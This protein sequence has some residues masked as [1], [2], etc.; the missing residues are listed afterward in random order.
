MT[1]SLADEAQR[2]VLGGCTKTGLLK[3]IAIITMIVDHMGVVF[4]PEILELRAVGRI[5]FPLYAWCLVVGCEYTRNLPKY[6]L[7]VLLMLIVSQ[8]F[9]MLALSHPIEELSIFATLL[10]GMI[11]IAGM[12]ERRYLSQLWAPALAL[13]AACLVKVDYGWKGVLFILL[14][15]G[16][17]KQRGALIAFMVAYCLYWGQG[18]STMYSIF[19]VPMTGL[20]MLTPYGDT[21]FKALLRVQTFALLAL[22]IMLMR[23]VRDI[24]LP[25]ALAY[26]AYPAHLLI[27]YLI[28]LMM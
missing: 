14:L 26:A 18:T 25:R 23:P 13:T 11:G 16:A 1:Y 17:R 6:A 28:R 9:Y 2:P 8:P 20:I 22:P 19:S 4:F 24:R 10:L 15:Y 27:I 3:L 7:R 12:K 21:L 5:A